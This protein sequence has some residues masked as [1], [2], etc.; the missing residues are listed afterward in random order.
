MD[1]AD[2]CPQLNRILS[3]NKLVTLLQPIL[4]LFE[5]SITGYEALTRD[6][7]DRLLFRFPEI[8]CGKRRHGQQIADQFSHAGIKQHRWRKS[9]DDGAIV[10]D[11]DLAVVA[12][13]L[14]GVRQKDVSR[15]A[16]TML[17]RTGPGV[18]RRGHEPALFRSWRVHPSWR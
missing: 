11:D 12:G 1:Y 6:M 13:V 3:D 16:R 14:A 7:L 5:G 17:A 8:Y 4:D 10:V 18:G 9:L 15:H 2:L